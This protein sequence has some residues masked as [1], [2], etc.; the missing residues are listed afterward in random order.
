MTTPVRERIIPCESRAALDRI[1][2]HSMR[3]LRPVRRGVMGETPLALVTA[4]ADFAWVCR[5]VVASDD[6]APARFEVAP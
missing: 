3:H 2:A 6:A 5:E 4:D 1:V